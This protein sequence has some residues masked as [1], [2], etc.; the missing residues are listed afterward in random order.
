MPKLPRLALIG[1]ILAASLGAGKLRGAP[2][3]EDGLPANLG[4]DLHALAAWQ[5][6]QTARQPETERK[7]ALVEHFRA[8]ASRLQMDSAGRVTVNLLLD[9][10]VP[11]ADV[12]KH[13][14][15]LGATVI[16]EHAARRADRR[17]GVLSVRLPV[18]RAIEAAQ[19]PGVHSVLSAHRPWRRTGSVPGQGVPVLHADQVIA[20]G[21]TGAGIT[22]GVISDSYDLTSP[23]AFLDVQSG[24]LPGN[25]I[26]LQDGNPSDNTNTDEGRAMMQI[27]HDVAPGATLAF[28]TSGDTQTTF[29]DAIHA[30]RT[31]SAARC[32]VIVDDIAFPDEPFFSDGIVSQ[33]VDDVVTSTTLPGRPVIFYS[34]SGNDGSGGYHADFNFISDQDAR[35]G[36][37]GSN[38]LIFNNLKHPAKSVPASLTAGGFHNFKAADA[39]KGK[40]IVQRVTVSGSTVEIDLQWDDPFLPSGI[41]TDYN[42]LVFNEN[43]VF[44]PGLSGTDDN[45]ST[46]EPLELVDLD[47]NPDGSARTYQLVISRAS[48]GGANRLFYVPDGGTLTGKF[49]HTGQP[50]LFGHPAAANADGVAAFDVHTPTVPEDFDSF[51]PVEI[52]FDSMGNHLA[53]PEER[54]QPDISAP[55]GVN[56]TFFPQPANQNDSDGDGFPNFYG[57]SAAAPHAAA[58]AALMLEAAGG[59]GSLTAA[60]MRNL[61]EST[62]VDH[63][64]DPAMCTATLTSADGQEQVT[65]TATGDD[66]ALSNA[67][68]EF[69]KV[70]FAGPAGSSLRKLVLNLGPAGETFDTSAGTGQPLKFGLAQGGL[71]TVDIAAKPASGNGPSLRLTAT[72]GTFVPG[73][74][75]SFGIGRDD[76][77]GNPSPSADQLAG[78]TVT[79]KCVLADG[80]RVNL[81]GAFANKTGH[82]YSPDVGYGLINAEAA[83][84]SLK[85]N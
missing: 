64:L 8:S 66:T 70:T 49:L 65:V 26:V 71:Q 45:F 27:V 73:A 35:S 80:S 37:A 74:A 15:S 61:L 58:V 31:N 12:R 83:F 21:T 39:G 14:E 42:L 51:G 57:T 78:A 2:V 53:A 23:P 75:L 10:T 36:N 79:A 50:T 62:A 1:C 16:G 19:S 46:G 40:Q 44:L 54:L 38:N 30:L 59:H 84:Q 6:T 63:D 4:H 29:A 48:G 7:R 13:L 68:P 33:A 24:D 77:S 82:G 22:V 76:A 3:A 5:R 81:T 17:D 20:A 18:E 28:N 9:G 43:G 47:P 85:Q 52:V 25:V 72:L 32:D 67:D 41:T 69:F 55:D 60:Q 11:A 34:A 56:T